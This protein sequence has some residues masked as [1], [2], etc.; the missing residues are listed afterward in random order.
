MPVAVW[1]LISLF[2]GVKAGVVIGAILAAA[3]EDAA[4]SSDQRRRDPVTDTAYDL[5]P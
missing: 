5:L 2:L 3:G 1:C 4:H